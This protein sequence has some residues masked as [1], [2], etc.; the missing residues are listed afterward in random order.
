MTNQEKLTLLQN[1]LKELFQ[2]EDNDLDFGIYRIINIKRK[3]IAEFI[4]KE[5]LD[6][7]KKE[8]KTVEDQSSLKEELE[9][10][11]NDIEQNFA[12]NIEEA[13]QKYKEIPK[14]KDYLEK[15]R[16]LKKA[17]KENDVEEEIYDDIVN[18][19]S[20]YYDN[21]D[22]I[23][24]RRYSKDNKYA[25]PYNGEEVYLYW[26]NNDQYYI[27]T[28][29]NF[30]HY[31]FKLSQLKVVFKIENE[32]VEVEKGNIKGDTKYFIFKDAEYD[33]SKKLLEVKFGYRPLSE[34][35]EK[36]VME[37][38]DK[39]RV[40]KDEVN[41]LNLKRIKEKIG[42]WGL[43]QLNACH[44]NLD[45]NKTMKNKGKDE[46]PEL[47]WHLN[48]YTTK[49]TTDY[50]IHKDLKKFL[51]QELDFYIKNELIHIDDIGKKKDLDYDL[52]R[53]KVFKEI[54]KRIIE[55]LGQI[56]NFQKKLWEKKKFVISTDYCITL[57]Y[58]DEKYYPQILESKKQLDEWK[59][60]FSFDVDL[61]TKKLKSTIHGHGN[62]NKKVEVLKLNPTLI[63]DTKFFDQEFKYVLLS[64][65]DGLDEKTNGILINSENFH[66]LN[67]ITTKYNEKIKTCQIDP[68][69]NTGHDDFVY[70]DG[71]GHSSWLCLLENRVSL[72]KRLLNDKG[73]FYAFCDD[74][75]MSSF[76]K[77]LDLL[78]DNSNHI[79]E[80]IWNSRKS[81]SNDTYVSLSHNYI[82]NYAKNINNI[83]KED[84]RIEADKSKFSN[85]DNDPKGD[86][87][88]DP[89]D[90]PQIRKNLQYEIKNP[91]TGEV[92]HPVRGRHWVVPEEEYLR[93]LKDNRIVFGKNGESKPQRK[94][95]WFEAQ[96]RGRTLTSIWND[97]ETTTNGTKLL[98]NL[99]GE[100]VFT[101]PKPV[102]VH[103]RMTKL[104]TYKDQHNICLD[105]FAGTG[106]TGHAILNL[107]KIDQGNRKFILIEMGGYFNTVL[108]PRIEKVIFSDNWKEGNPQ[109]NNGSKK[110]IIKYQALEQYEDTLLNIDFK[111]PNKLVE[112]SKDFKLKYMLEFES[113]E[114]KV[115]LNIDALSNPFDYKLK[116]EKD[117]EVRE[118]NVDLIE[119]FN[120]MAGI[121][122]DKIFTDKNEKTDY[123]FVKGTKGEKDVLVIWRNTGKSF[124]PEKE[125]KWLLSGI[126][127]EKYDEV[128]TN[129]NSLIPGAKT[130]EEVIRTNMI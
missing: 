79:S 67:L 48:K 88:A 9:A 59:K 92:F 12:C 13:K 46:V 60:L 24:K 54:S 94:R 32:E 2:F 112:S 114:S 115:F 66:A 68:P 99:F 26:A 98:D 16:E 4:D 117:N 97:C 107:N 45:G 129:G 110:Q 39:K 64:E 21:G 65:I 5:L 53:I 73:I 124:D 37:V 72:S 71:Y 62:G 6:I 41:A 89:F 28:A 43:S 44:I 100:R 103:E 106:T 10:L 85:P 58:I 11:K 82:L 78:F 36:E 17:D 76:R 90:A 95:Y 7:I 56:E 3:E 8:I 80:I 125:K 91:N 57:D 113:K 127:K 108:K 55:F 109:D 49:N 128:F 33:S 14:I 121:E 77:L 126:L 19:F 70:K 120:Y 81:V 118:H 102:Q 40:G 20:R 61:E 22:F 84:Y 83:N 93:L 15:E 47:D 105:Y 50:F 34:D 96:E 52:T 1:K 74:N 122:V 119:T 104:S 87:V 27:K 86:W 35:E 111:E 101:N 51:S 23:S 30:R 25:I 123:V 42:V 130:V 29:E 75:E 31:S 18:F 63:L 38:S 69:Y 116:I